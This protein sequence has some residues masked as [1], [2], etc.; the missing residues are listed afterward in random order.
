MIKKITENRFDEVLE[1]DYALVDFSASW[2]GPC[3]MLAPVVDALAEEMSDQVA[4]FGV[5][6]DENADLAMKYR[7]MSVPSILLFRNGSLV[8]QAVGYQDKDSLKR[9]IQEN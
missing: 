5:D 1:Q 8:A 6:V 7:V 2:C 9:F 3:Q 4:F